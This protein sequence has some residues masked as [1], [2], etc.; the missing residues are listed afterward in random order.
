MYKLSQPYCE[1][2][3]SELSE[4]KDGV[5]IYPWIEAASK[6][7]SIYYQFR[8]GRPWNVSLRF[9]DAD[10]AGKIRLLS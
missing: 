9:F 1:R 4:V 7:G 5:S 6:F 8:I 2:G 3:Y 10:L